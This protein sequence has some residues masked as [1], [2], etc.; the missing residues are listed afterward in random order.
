MSRRFKS[1]EVRGGCRSAEGLGSN[2]TVIYENIFFV[3]IR[4]LVYDFWAR[5]KILS[6]YISK[7]VVLG[8]VHTSDISI[9]ASS[10][11]RHSSAFIT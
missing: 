4:Y 7:Q 1:I 10:I 5:E 6:V 3:K 2:L 8:P 11:H 9:S